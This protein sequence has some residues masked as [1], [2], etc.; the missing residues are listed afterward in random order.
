MIIEINLEAVTKRLGKLAELR[1]SFDPLG[2][3]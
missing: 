1:K 2:P 3:Q